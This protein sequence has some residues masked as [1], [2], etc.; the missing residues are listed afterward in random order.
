MLLRGIV[1]FVG[2]LALFVAGAG[3]VHAQD[4]R[5]HLAYE[6]AAEASACPDDATLR[7]AVAARLGYV[8]FEATAVRTVR[9]Q[10]ARRGS[11]VSARIEVLEEGRVTGSRELAARARP[12]ACPIF[13]A[14]VM[15][16]SLAIDPMTLSHPEVPPEPLP[17][18]CPA[19]EPCPVCEVCPAPA[20]DRAP[21]DTTAPAIDA[22]P[23]LAASA[24]PSASLRLS[25]ALLFALGPL[26][27]PTGALRIA[28]GARVL[29]VS[30]DLE[31]RA[32]LPSSGSDDAGHTASATWLSATLALCGHLDVLALCGLL[33]SG[34]LVGW[35]GGVTQPRTDVT[36][37]SSAGARVGIEVP[38]DDVFALAAAAEGSFVVTPTTL[39]VDGRDVHV[40][41]PVVASVSL[42]M[43]FSIR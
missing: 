24:S 1:T 10:L 18:V 37:F 33:S 6:R 27:Q 21:R 22:A 43:L 11:R 30:A 14:L 13:E 42:G 12:E 26:P 35:G 31:L 29:D 7:D 34:A 4:A 5:V 15:A 39:T 32:D 20:I 9:V 8:P 19:P 25:G 36:G 40:T 23:S 38:I 28:A 3:R 41:P 16:V 17:T 2:A